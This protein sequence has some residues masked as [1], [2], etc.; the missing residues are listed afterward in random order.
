MGFT[1]GCADGISDLADT[2]AEDT[3]S[4]QSYVDAKQYNASLLSAFYG[5]DDAIPFLASYR[6][7]SEFGHKDGMPVIFSKELD[8][9][10][11]Q[12]GDFEV[13]LTDGTA[14]KPGCVTPAP[15]EDVGELRTMLM[16]GDF[17]SIDN[18]PISVEIV[19]NLISADHQSN[20]LGTMVAVSVG[21][22][23]VVIFR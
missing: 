1:A 23:R 18:Q 12:A 4:M 9:N 2:N 20:F 6:I 5:L 21:T 14:V 11:L 10:S 22:P 3:T 7:C 15:A 19:G 8:L 17:G 13:T 16:I